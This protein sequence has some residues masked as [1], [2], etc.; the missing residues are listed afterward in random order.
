[1]NGERASLARC[2]AGRCDP[3]PCTGP[4]AAAATTTTGDSLKGAV[5]LRSADRGRS[6][7]RRRS[8]GGVTAGERS[9]SG[10]GLRSDVAHRRLGELDFRG[11]RLRVDAVP[12][13]GVVHIPMNVVVAVLG[14]GQGRRLAN[15]RRGIVLGFVTMLSMVR[16][17]VRERVA[18]L[19]ECGGGHQASRQEATQDRVAHWIGNLAAHPSGAPMARPA[20]CIAN[21]EGEGH[22]QPLHR[23]APKRPAQA[24]AYSAYRIR[25]ARPYV[26]G[27]LPRSEP[28][29]VS[30]SPCTRGGGAHWQSRLACFPRARSRRARSR[31]RLLRLRRPGARSPR[32]R[33]GGSVE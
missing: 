15:R 30:L 17:P 11:D 10:R 16:H 13:A 20:P 8:G 4:V 27:A 9:A 26:R 31:R 22:A 25:L 5:G 1:M 18:R 2:D 21:H 28:R 33:H 12:D 14:T 32:A 6:Q 7:A 24:R 3:V 19:G 29:C 23:Q